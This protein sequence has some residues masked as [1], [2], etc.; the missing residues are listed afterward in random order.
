MSKV[1]KNETIFLDNS[2]LIFVFVTT[3]VPSNEKESCDQKAEATNSRVLFDENKLR[4]CDRIATTNVCAKIS[5]VPILQ[6][7]TMN[8]VYLWHSSSQGLPLYSSPSISVHFDK[9]A[10]I[11]EPLDLRIHCA[12]TA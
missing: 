8:D 12:S 11:D 3:D 1:T 9:Y 10:E 6:T 4:N 2:I 5:S 7:C